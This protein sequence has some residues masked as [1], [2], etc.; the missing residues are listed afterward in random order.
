MCNSAGKDTFRPL[1][2]SIESLKQLL[3]ETGGGWLDDLIFTFFTTLLNFITEYDSETKDFRDRL[4]TLAFGDTIDDVHRINPSRRI[5]EFKLLCNYD[6]YAS[7]KNDTTSEVKKWY[8]STNGSNIDRI[9]AAYDGKK[10]VIT[11]I[12]APIHTSNHYV[13]LDVILPNE[14]NK[15]GYVSIYNYHRNIRTQ[16]LDIARMW[17]AKFF[18]IY[19]KEKLY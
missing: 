9:L 10:Q 7:D 5:N 17:W 8:E 3:L 16:S 13:L 2:L 4:P 15:N 6:D 14:D 18:G 1:F 11:H 12:C 19:S